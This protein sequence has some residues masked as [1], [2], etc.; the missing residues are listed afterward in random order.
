MVRIL[1]RVLVFLVSAAVGILVAAAVLD[2]VRISASGFL[3]VVII[4]TVIQSVISPF[5]AKMAALHASAFLGGTGLA[6]TFVALLLAKLFGDALTIDGGVT[7]WIAATVIVW[8]VTAVATLCVPLL[9]VKAG[10]RAAERRP[11]TRR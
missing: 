8:L 5:I 9:L 7:T 2:D 3:F 1:V 10:V 6:A 4:Y 11:V